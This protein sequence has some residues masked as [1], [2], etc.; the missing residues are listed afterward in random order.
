MARVLLELSLPGANWLGS[1]KARYPGRIV[2]DAPAPRNQKWL[3][4][5]MFDL[6]YDLPCAAFN[7]AAA[8]Q[9][10]SACRIMQ[11]HGDITTHNSA[12]KCISIGL[13]PVQV[14][15]LFRPGP[16]LLRFGPGTFFGPDSVHAQHLLMICSVGCSVILTVASDKGRPG[17][18]SRSRKS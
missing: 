12:A 14:S 8:P 17:S 7:A 15:V 2:N 10:T 5:M 16:T 6:P 9:S 11:G 4:D 1:E 13:G 3:T 18:R